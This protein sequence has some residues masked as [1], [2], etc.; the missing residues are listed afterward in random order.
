MFHEV[1]VRRC[2]VADCAGALPDRALRTCPSHLPSH[3]VHFVDVDRFFVAVERQDD[4]EPDRRFGRRHRDDEDREHLADR[5]LQLRRK[6][7]PD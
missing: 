1:R 6:T 4:A 5:V 2:D 3:Q 7:R